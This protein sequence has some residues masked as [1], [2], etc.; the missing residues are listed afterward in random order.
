MSGTSRTNQILYHPFLLWSLRHW[1]LAMDIPSHQFSS[2]L[3][4]ILQLI[5]NS[6]FFALDLEFSGIS[7][8]RNRGSKSKSSLQEVYEEI[9]EAA[10]QYQVLQVGLTLVEEDAQKGTSP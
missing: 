2:E 10:I 3:V 7:S 9:K 8:R 6:H 5:A 1:V 4:R